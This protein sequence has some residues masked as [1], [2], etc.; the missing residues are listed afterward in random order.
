MDSTIQL[1]LEEGVKTRIDAGEKKVSIVRWLI[2]EGAPNSTIFS[3]I[4][5][6]P[7]VVCRVRQKMGE[8]AAYER[9]S[10]QQKQ[11]T[12][13]LFDEQP[14][15][16]ASVEKVE[17]PTT[18]EPKLQTAAPVRQVANVEEV[19]TDAAPKQQ[20]YSILIPVALLLLIPALIGVAYANIYYVLIQ[21]I[22]PNSFSALISTIALEISPFFIFITNN[23]ITHFF[24]KRNRVFEWSH[25][26]RAILWVLCIVDIVG[27]SY[28]LTVINS[29]PPVIGVAYA[30]VL[31][32]LHTGIISLANEVLL[33]WERERE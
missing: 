8:P 2:Q 27:I 29:S 4:K 5:V 30:V 18:E 7:S 20:G 13:T 14:I 12:V 22:T 25:L 21:Q 28:T 6:D 24:K 26:F 16:M 31:T 11:K 23:A 15:P 1:T 17:K 19:R 3:L 10:V 9:K 32:I 33:S